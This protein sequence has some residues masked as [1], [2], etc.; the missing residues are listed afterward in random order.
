M[1]TLF[2][3]DWQFALKEIDTSSI[4]SPVDFLQDFSQL[5]YESIQVPHDWMISDTLDLYKNSVGF[6]KKDFILDNTCIS[7]SFSLIRACFLCPLT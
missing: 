5:S 2:N 3:D 6:Y 4:L 7:N 1:K